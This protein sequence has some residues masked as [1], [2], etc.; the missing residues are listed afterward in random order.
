[1]KWTS[2]WAVLLFPP[3]LIVTAHDKDKRRNGYVF[4]RFSKNKRFASH[5]LRSR[6]AT[7]AAGEAAA[8]SSEKTAAPGL[9]ESFRQ[10]IDALPSHATAVERFEI[11]TAARYS[12]PLER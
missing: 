3:Q 8:A 11:P 1:M 9:P 12:E 2:D 4:C 10:K 5:G 6:G 7:D